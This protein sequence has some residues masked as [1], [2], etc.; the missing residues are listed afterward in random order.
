M[1][2]VS[3]CSNCGG[4]IIFRWLGGVNTPIHLSGGCYETT[5]AG[6]TSGHHVRYDDDYCRPTNCPRCGCSVFF[7]RHNGGSVWVDELGW[8]W[9]KH[10]C[11]DNEASREYGRLVG[12]S[13]RFATPTAGVVTSV[14]SL[15]SSQGLVLGIRTPEGH[16]YVWLIRSD[17]PPPSVVGSLVLFSTRERRITFA[18]GAETD[19]LEAPVRCAVCDERIPRTELE[20]HMAIRHHAIRCR[21]CGHYVSQSGFRAHERSHRSRRR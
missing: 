12:L 1:P 19:L 3:R 4:D 8:P 6:T 18:N 17:T 16:D 5:T 9:P 20:A 15:P 11:F 13:T 14:E 2:D 7:I 10:A 21:A